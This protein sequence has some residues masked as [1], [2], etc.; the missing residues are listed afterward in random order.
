MTILMIYL[1]AEALHQTP[2]FDDYAQCMY[3]L[4]YNYR[5]LVP[6]ICDKLILRHYIDNLKC[7]ISFEMKCNLSS[8]ISRLASLLSNV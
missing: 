5:I 4:F 8:F 1:P 3:G 7:L 6:R 2:I